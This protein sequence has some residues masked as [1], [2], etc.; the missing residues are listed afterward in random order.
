MDEVRGWLFD[1]YSHPERGV[2]LWVIANSGERLRLRME[3][4]ITLYLAGDFKL[5][6]AAWIFLTGKAELARTK[7]RDLFLGERDVMQ[8]TLTENNDLIHELQSQFPSLDYYDADIPITLRFI[9]H[10]GVYLLGRCRLTLDRERV[11]SIQ[12]LDSP[13]ELSPEPIPLRVMEL[14]PDADPAFRQPTRLKV[15]T[16]RGGYFIN[17][18]P[19]RPFLIS[20]QAD[21]RHYDPDLILTDHGDGWLMPKLADIEINRD[22]ERGTQTRKANSYFAYGQTIHRGA[23]SHLFGRWHIDRR[24]AM[25]FNEYGLEG[26]MEQSRVTGIGVQ[27]MARKSPGAG[28]TAMQ[29]LTALR[30]GVMIPLHKQQAEGSKTLAG[31]IR[32][33]KGGLIYQ[34]TLGVHRD[35]AQI[36]FASMY[37]SIMVHHNISPETLG[38]KDAKQGLIPQTLAPLLEKR[39]KLK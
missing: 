25:M 13:W 2:V 8:V 11:Q 5:L 34:P 19:E 28:I 31:L 18:E 27:E 22:R 36:D 29:M 9:A 14:S 1:V 10:T 23:Q 20:L 26:V 24:N 39:L 32:A 30:T 15:K 6:R 21:L 3:L 37:P 12:A 4:P 16:E 7:R 35:V 33:D 38:K 17:M